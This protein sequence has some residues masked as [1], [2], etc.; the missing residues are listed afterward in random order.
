MP[1]KS[2]RVS[3]P[4]LFKELGRRG[5][6]HILSEGGGAMAGSLVRGGLVDEFHFFI[7]P[8][9]IGGRAAVDAVGGTGWLLKNAPKLIFEECK[10]IGDD[11][12]VI[13]RPNI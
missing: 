8:K 5:M 10:P 1:A 13:A 2:G 9:I 4:R 7:A 3:L 12:L 6:L 11:L